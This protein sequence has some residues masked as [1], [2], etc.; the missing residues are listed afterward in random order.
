MEYA[1]ISEMGEALQV[2]T[3]GNVEWDATHFCTASSLTLE[4]AEFFRVVPLILTEPPVFNPDTQSV[5]RNGCIQLDGIW[6]SHWSVLELYETQDSKDTAM[7][8]RAQKVKKSILS[9]ITL[10][11]DRRKFGGVKV[12]SQWIHTDTYSR[13]QWLGMAMMGAEVPSIEW[14]TMDGTSIFTSQTLVR[15]VFQNTAQLDTDVFNYAKTLI[16]QVEKAEEP[17]LVDILTGWPTT[18]SD[19]V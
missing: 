10:E 9:Q 6:Y 2:T 11:L 5:I 16:T 17:L 4:E 12:G 15:S 1:Q 8:L 14:T 7:A 19:I 3:Q 13:T 18:F